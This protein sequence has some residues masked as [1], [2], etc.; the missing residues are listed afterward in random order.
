MDR[1]FGEQVIDRADYGSL[2]LTTPEGAPYVIPLS[3]AREGEHLY[4]HS[5]TGG[6][7]VD[8]V[9]EGMRVQIL[10]VGRVQVPELYTEEQLQEMAADESRARD[11]ARH[12]FTTEYESSIVTGTIHRVEE[13]EEHYHAHRVL[14]ERF[15]PSKMH[16]FEAAYRSGGPRTLIYRIDIES[17][18]A[19]RKHYDHTPRG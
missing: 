15:T 10:F 19:K 1:A 4:F 8:L 13:P 18:T 2:A 17:V 5:A 3:I 9:E 7:K 14:C 12:V 6:T 16:L 11:L